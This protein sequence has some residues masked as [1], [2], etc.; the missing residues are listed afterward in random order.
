[1]M[2][3]DPIG[4]EVMYCEM[5]FSWRDFRVVDS[6]YAFRIGML[7]VV[8]YHGDGMEMW[9]LQ[10]WM[11]GEA[12]SRHR[13]CHCVVTAM[14]LVRPSLLFLMLYRDSG[15][16][17]VLFMAARPLAIEVDGGLAMMNEFLLCLWLKRKDL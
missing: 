1:M 14:L 3:I 12:F 11:R 4:I 5:R 13:H 16:D 10:I 9:R 15:W 17:F 2:R 7:N 8:L 6:R